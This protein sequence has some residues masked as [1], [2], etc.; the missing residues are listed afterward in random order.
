M[1]VLVATNHLWHYAGSEQWTRTMVQA[2][3]RQGH[4]VDCFA[5]ERG[6]A[7]ANLPMVDRPALRYDLALL[8]HTSIQ[9]LAHLIDA[10]KIAT[11]HGPWH[12][13]EQPLAGFDHYVAVSPEVLARLRQ[14]H[15]PSTLLPN[16]IDRTHF[17][18]GPP[19]W[20]GATA[21]GRRGRHR[22]PDLFA[23]VSVHAV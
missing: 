10:V 7:T 11:S 21:G 16:P 12:T 15:L 4:E 8:N 9:R 2:L 13:L 20:A 3:Q 1:K 23:Q 6:P 22:L 19:R 17:T 14:R 18:P 5:F